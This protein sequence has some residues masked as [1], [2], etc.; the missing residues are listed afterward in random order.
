MAWRGIQREEKN[1]HKRNLHVDTFLRRFLSDFTVT[2]LQ[3]SY[4]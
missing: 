3:E 2:C 1:R 4:A